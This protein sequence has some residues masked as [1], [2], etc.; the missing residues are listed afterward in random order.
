MYKILDSLVRMLAPVLAHT[1]EEAWAAIEHKSEDVDTVHLASMPVADA[2]IDVSDNEDKW[3]KV[4][5]LRDEV[6]KVLEGLRA[7]Q[8]IRSNQEAPVQIE[9]DDGELLTI[10]ADMGIETFA[11]LCIVSE[12][13]IAKGDALKVSAEKCSHAKCER[14]WYY[15]PSVGQNA[16]KPDLCDRCV[17]VVAGL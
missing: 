4:M 13:R 10:V 12:V 2:S 15:Y 14:C 9:T 17:N 6:L 1:A 5:T 8:I 3:A 16:D 11:S 7:E